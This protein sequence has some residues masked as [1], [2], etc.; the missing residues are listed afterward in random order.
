MGQCS[1]LSET[2]LTLLL[3]WVRSAVRS[4]LTASQID[5]MAGYTPRALS[6]LIEN[7]FVLQLN[8]GIG[9]LAK[10]GPARRRAFSQLEIDRAHRAMLKGNL[11]PSTMRFYQSVLGIRQP[12]EYYKIN[13][14]ALPVL[15]ESLFGLPNMV[16][17]TEYA[18]RHELPPPEVKAWF[19]DLIATDR[20]EIVTIR[21]RRLLR[22][23]ETSIDSVANIAIIPMIHNSS[24]LE[25]PTNSPPSDSNPCLTIPS[26]PAYIEAIET[27]AAREGIEINALVI[28]AIGLY[29][30]AVEA[31]R[32]NSGL[33]FTRLPETN[34]LTVKEIVRFSE[35]NEQNG[36]LSE[37]RKAPKLILPR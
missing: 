20:A 5:A 29:A 28:R 37:A 10:P 19:R 2:S 24:D 14:I 16:T 7:E 12:S 13:L 6:W 26:T 3:S 25:N 22:V 30:M 11:K 35:G 34:D 9:P 33:T 27:L 31:E 23:R 36:G 21:G 15:F 1:T 18:S 17:A 4:T 32:D 8:R